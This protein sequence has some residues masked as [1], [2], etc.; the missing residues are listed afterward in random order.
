[1]TIWDTAGN[2][3]TMLNNEI[4][5]KPFGDLGTQGMVSCHLAK[6]PLTPGDYTLNLSV[7]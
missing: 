3:V 6:L 2:C 5:S 1:M 7:S 4:A